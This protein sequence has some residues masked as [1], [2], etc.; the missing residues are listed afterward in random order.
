VSKTQVEEIKKK[1][2][3]A[4]QAVADVE[5]PFKTKAFEVILSTLLKKSEAEERVTPP[6]S[7][8]VITKGA[9][10]LDQKIAA[11]ANEANVE[12]SKLKDIFEFEE[13]KPIFIGNV[14]GSEAEKQVQISKCLIVA[15]KNVY[16]KAWVKVA[17]LSEALDDYGVGS[18]A[19][20]A[21]NLGKCEEEFR[22][23]GQ[24]RG[25]QYKLTQQGI[26]NAL[27]LIRQLST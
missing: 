3:L 27:D 11:F 17:L 26:K 21:A 12:A 23:K 5:E 10:T 2:Q 24:R 7:T 8:K 9:K 1:I 16:G 20:L 19:N 25:R 18:L 4:I 22:A 14:E 15:Y 13:D 6:S